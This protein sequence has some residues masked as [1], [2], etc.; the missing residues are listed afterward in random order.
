ML[1]L[2][3]KEFLESVCSLYHVRYF[4]GG[5]RRFNLAVEPHFSDFDLFVESSS[6]AA[7]L[8]LALNLKLAKENSGYPGTHYE[9]KIFNFD[10]DVL[11]L[12]EGAWEDLEEEHLN[13]QSFLASNPD[14]YETLDQAK[15]A[16]IIDGQTAYRIANHRR[17]L[18]K[19]F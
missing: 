15:R 8:M 7:R 18:K 6:N 5:S 9:T 2:L 4:W 3:V 16:R 14:L 11:L 13:V 19:E 1:D 10:V 12:K 17:I